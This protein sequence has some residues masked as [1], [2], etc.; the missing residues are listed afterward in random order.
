MG[1]SGYPTNERKQILELVRYTIAPRTKLPTHTHP[2]MQIERVEAGTLT[3]T[4]VKGE[5]RVT[6]ANSTELILK[7]GKTVLLTVGDSLVEPAGMVHYGE[8]QTNKPVILLSASLFNANQPKA[9]LT[10]PENK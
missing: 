5:A 4:V 2:G 9:I 7:T 8:N 6:K 3:Y 10:I 1:I